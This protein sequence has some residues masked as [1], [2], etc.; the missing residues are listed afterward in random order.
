[1]RCFSRG[2]RRASEGLCKRKKG[3][4]GKSCIAFRSR[5]KITAES[6]CKRNTKHLRRSKVKR[7]AFHLSFS[8]VPSI[9]PP[10][11]AF[12]LRLIVNNCFLIVFDARRRWEKRGKF[13]LSSFHRLRSRRMFKLPA[14]GSRLEGDGKSSINSASH[15]KFSNS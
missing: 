12:L 14:T 2:F 11:N 15:R 13:P 5:I 7:G 6:R 1:M 4:R 10:W 3:A 8:L 9:H